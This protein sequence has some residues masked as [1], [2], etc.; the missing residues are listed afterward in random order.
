MVLFVR[1]FPF[2]RAHDMADSRRRNVAALPRTNQTKPM[3]IRPERPADAVSIRTLTEAA[4]EGV[5][6]SHQTEG[7]IVDALRQGSAL[8]VSLVAELDGR[9]IGHVA[10]SPVR[11]DGES[12]GWFGLGP[13]SVLPGFQRNGVGKALIGEGL[14][15]LKGLGARGC[16]VLGD[17]A[18]YRKFGFTSDHGLRY[19]EVPAEYFRS[20]LLSGVPVKG[21]VTYHPGFDAC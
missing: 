2:S 1:R 12:C 16:V 6:H 7:A 19:G 9:I 11:I 18:Y 21:E 8:S 13:V 15:Q 5:E 20:L 3:I 10:F 14:R 17:P 4:F